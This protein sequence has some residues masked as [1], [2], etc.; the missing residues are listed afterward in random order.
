MHTSPLVL[1]F[2]PAI[3]QFPK[4]GG[5]GSRVGEVFGVGSLGQEGPSPS[6]VTEQV[7]SGMH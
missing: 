7:P 5:P 6:K 1:I 2:P 4:G 3:P